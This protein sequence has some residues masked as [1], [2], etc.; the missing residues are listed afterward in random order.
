MFHMIFAPLGKTNKFDFALAYRKNS[1]FRLDGERV[2]SQ[3]WF[4]KNNLSHCQ[5][6]AVMLIFAVIL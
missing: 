5:N 3:I 6:V 1:N 2:E 4:C